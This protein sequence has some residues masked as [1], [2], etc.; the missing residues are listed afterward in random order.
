MQ[1]AASAPPPSNCDTC[2]LRK[3]NSRDERASQAGTSPLP[4]AAF[5]TDRHGTFT[6]DTVLFRRAAMHCQH[7]ARHL[8]DST[9]KDTSVIGTEEHRLML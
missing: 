3:N 7:L 5:I 4:S 2:R 1:Q 9:D 8:R 6:A